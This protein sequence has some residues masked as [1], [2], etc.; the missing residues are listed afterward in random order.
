MISHVFIYAMKVFLRLYTCLVFLSLLASFS[1]RSISKDTD[2]HEKNLTDIATMYHFDTTQYQQ[3][4]SGFYISKS[5]DIFQLNRIVY[6]DSTGRWITHYWL[7]SLMF[8]GEY[9]NRRPLKEI[10]DL[11]TFISDTIS[12]FE[13]DKNHVYFARATSDGVYRYIVENADPKTFIAIAGRWGKD[14]AN[15]FY[16]TDIVKDA[17]AES[18]RVLD[19]RDS[20]RDRRHIYYLGERVK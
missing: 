9:P 11:A 6:D 3:H 1:C 14:K 19:G 10:I 2:S 5:S 12:N 15:I 20:A 17:D 13:S 7:D 16:G 4:E 18:F 8:Y